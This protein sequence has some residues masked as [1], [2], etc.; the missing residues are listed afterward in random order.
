MN[1]KPITRPGPV[2]TSTVA[3]G[4][5]VEVE[6]YAHPDLL[7]PDARRLFDEAERRNIGFGL[8]WYRTLVD[9]VFADD[10][11]VRFHVLRIDGEPV[12]ALPTVARRDR[13]GW[14]TAALGNY[15]TSLYAPVFGPGSQGADLAPLIRAVR[16]TRPGAGA[17]VFAPM[18]PDSH[19]FRS[20]RSGLRAAGL[21]AFDY[22]CFGN[23]YLP[24]DG[25]AW[26]GYLAS[27]PSDLR[28]TL[29]RKAKKLEADGGTF[30]V[31]A[32]GPDVE[33]GIAAFGQVY[34]SSWKQPEP[35]PG[36]VPGLIETCRR[37]GW[38]RLG[39][40][41]LGGRPIAAQLWI[42][43]HGRAE[44]YKLAYDEAFKRYSA[45]SL[46]TAHLMR[47]VLEHDRVAEVDYLIGDD[48]Y[49]ETWMT[50]R[51]ERRGLIAYDPRRIGGLAGLAV[52]V[53]GRI[54]KPWLARLKSSSK[55]PPPEPTGETGE[56]R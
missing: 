42:V 10:D 34:A 7:P 51:R 41:R 22:F 8:A 9:H 4:A 12:A 20:L 13:F 40:V 2:P 1:G 24:C 54:V 33:A 15:Y 39:V 19:A 27:R 23:W 16:R 32:D 18:D 3:R 28:N 6:A 46:L 14:Q 49:K 36:F 30:E 45:G 52:E 37:R 5:A 31:V 29:K 38:L 50:H 56:C 44:I 35:Y 11:S 55:P 21:V 47:H 53:A 26:P 25:V 43:A 48:P 17:L